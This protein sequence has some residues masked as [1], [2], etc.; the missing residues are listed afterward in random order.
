[1]SCAT[2]AAASAAN[3]HA[4]GCAAG[5]QSVP[6]SRHHASTAS[7]HEVRY[8]IPGMFAAGALRVQRGHTS[9]SSSYLAD[10]LAHRHGGAVYV[11]TVGT[12]ELETKPEDLLYDIEE[13]YNRSRRR[14]ALLLSGCN[15]TNNTAEASGGEPSQLCAHMY[16]YTIHRQFWQ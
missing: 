11:G 16:I 12:A 14:P 10:N 1:M 15:V 5:V 6:V 7:Y 2:Y 13:C 4:T 9:I 3:T 8:L